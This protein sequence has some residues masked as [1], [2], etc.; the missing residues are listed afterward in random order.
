MKILFV[1][2]NFPYDLKTAVSGMD[3][4]MAMFVEALKG[5]GELDM[6]FYV[7]FEFSVDAGRQQELEN[8]LASRW[9]A[10]LRLTLCTMPSAPKSRSLW[11]TYG[12][13][14]L[15]FY[16][17]SPNAGVSGL[18][19]V[20][21]FR[22][23]LERGPNAIFAHRLQSMCPLLLAQQH[24]APVF[25]DLD[26]VE[27]VAFARSIRQPP[28]WGSKPLRYLQLPALIWGER[29][30]IQRANKTFVCSEKDCRYL[31][32]VW[33]LPGITTIPNAVR[34]PDSTPVPDTRNLLFLGRHSY[35]PNS[36]AA[37][38]LIRHIWPSVRRA[39][40]DARLIIAGERPQDIPSYRERPE[41]VEFRGFIDNLDE[42]YR[43]TRVVCCPI[44]SGGG[45]RFKIVEAAAYGRPIVAS[46]L[47]AEG[48]AMRDG[49]SILLRDDP[50]SFAHACILLLQDNRVAAQLGDRARQEAILAF[51]KNNIV[52]QIRKEIT[53][54][55]D[56]GR[57]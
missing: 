56:S 39:C 20:R 36:N 2:C 9:G 51:D 11:K 45:T 10:K 23:C 40:P 44:H 8:E 16:R 34:I 12:P 28:F 26:D 54:C 15:S 29:R 32:S 53:T 18:E 1:S 46:S 19:Q 48:L 24:T 55:L 41:G 37:E 6:L 22:H 33:R 57:V 27:H 43:N 21:A 50:E 25:L 35:A 13:G 7:P 14:T 31:S 4:R 5:L 3:R 47:G 38:H 30:A 42:L 52:R 49:D 17:Q